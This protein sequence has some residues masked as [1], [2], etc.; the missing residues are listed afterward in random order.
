MM[1]DILS[2]SFHNGHKFVAKSYAASTTSITTQGGIAP[3][4]PRHSM[5]EAMLQKVIVA[6]KKP[7]MTIDTAVSKKTV[8]FPFKSPVVSF[9]H[10]PSGYLVTKLQS[11]M[12]WEHPSQSAGMLLSIL[13]GV[14]LTQFYSLLYMSSAAFTLL[15]AFNWVYVNL[16]FHSNR[17]LSGKSANDIAHPHKVTLAGQGERRTWITEDQVNHSCHMVLNVL[18]GIVEKLM[19]LVLIE[20]SRQ[21]G[22]AV[23][24]S[25]VLWTLASLIST[26]SLVILMSLVFFSAPRLYL[27]HQVKVD[28]YLTQQRENLMAWLKEHQKQQ[29]ILYQFADRAQTTALSFASVAMRTG[30]KL[31]DQYQKKSKPIGDKPLQ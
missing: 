29:V 18:E 23:V 10:D 3:P 6:E 17:I 13:G 16:H 15:T 21:S 20:D 12:Y 14:Y 8:S 24:L 25:F 27:E 9:N 30:Q 7:T 28:R 11:L 4:S 5:D 22:W 2:P 31:Y 19:K 26:K 1:M